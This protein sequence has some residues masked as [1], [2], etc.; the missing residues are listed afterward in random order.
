MNEN[1]S[2]LEM[3]LYIQFEKRVGFVFFFGE[4]QMRNR[5]KNSLGSQLSLIQFFSL[6]LIFSIINSVRSPCYPLLSMLLLK[7]VNC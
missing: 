5:S 2:D 4:G 7:E 3:L 1:N 6:P